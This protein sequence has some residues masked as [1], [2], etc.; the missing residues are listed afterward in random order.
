[1]ARRSD[2]PRPADVPPQ[3]ARAQDSI[4]VRARLP[5]PPAHRLSGS[6]LCCVCGQSL[7]KDNKAAEIKQLV[8]TPG[9]AANYGNQ[10]GQTALHIAA[11]WG[12]SALLA[13]A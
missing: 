7:A 5:H 9:I 1:M 10:I 3:L 13:A 4:L 6:D 2:G 11:I 8:A 12:V